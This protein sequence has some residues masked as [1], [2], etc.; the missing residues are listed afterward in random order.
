MG[1]RGRWWMFIHI[2][3]YYFLLLTVLIM[4]TL[5]DQPRS[6]FGDFMCLLGSLH[7]RDM[8]VLIII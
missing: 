3:N 1:E 7:S 8:I 4:L 2:I 6:G 5:V